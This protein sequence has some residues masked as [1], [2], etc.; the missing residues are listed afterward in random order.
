MY[1]FL[2]SDEFKDVNSLGIDVAERGK[3]G[4]NY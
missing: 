1:S 3:T 2:Q 4:M